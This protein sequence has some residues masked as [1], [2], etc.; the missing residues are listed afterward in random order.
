MHRVHYDTDIVPT[1]LRCAHSPYE[2][3]SKKIWYQYKTCGT[4]MGH[5][6]SLVSEESYFDADDELTGVGTPLFRCEFWYWGMRMVV[7][8][9]QSRVLP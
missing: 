5:A 3:Y 6:G 2:K 1:L 9:L 7:G 4:E 8:A